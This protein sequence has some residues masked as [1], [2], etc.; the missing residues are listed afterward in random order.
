MP[1]VKRSQQETGQKDNKIPQIWIVKYFEKL[2]NPELYLIIASFC[3]NLSQKKKC[4]YIEYEC[5]VINV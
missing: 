2:W 3:I 4:Q 5:K 1:C